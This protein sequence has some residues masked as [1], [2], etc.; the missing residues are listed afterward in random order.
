[1]LHSLARNNPSAP[2]LTRG[3]VPTR[4]PPGVPIPPGTEDEYRTIVF[5]KELSVTRCVSCGGYDRLH[6]YPKKDQEQLKKW[7]QFCK[8]TQSYPMLCYKH[9]EPHWYD[10]EEK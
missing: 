10:N 1:M 6:N 8:P 3:A 4:F 7:R 5:D 9:F 2:R